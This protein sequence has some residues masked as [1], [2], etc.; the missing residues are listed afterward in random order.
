MNRYII[1][2]TRNRTTTTVAAEGLNEYQALTQVT[3][4]MYDACDDL[5]SKPVQCH[6]I[7]T[8]ETWVYATANAT[9]IVKRIRYKEA[10]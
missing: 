9:H 2:T 3:D 6:Y 5:R 10:Q 1:Q 8:E 4:A 7:P